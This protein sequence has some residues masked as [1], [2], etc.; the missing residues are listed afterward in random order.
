MA[1]GLLRVLCLAR[2]RWADGM[3]TQELSTQVESSHTSRTGI[4]D[5]KIRLVGFLDF[6]YQLSTACIGASL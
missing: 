2:H 3:F 5:S 1:R 4:N 6:I